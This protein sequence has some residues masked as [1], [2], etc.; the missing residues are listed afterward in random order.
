MSDFRTCAFARQLK[1]L[2]IQA[3]LKQPVAWYWFIFI[4][5]DVYAKTNCYVAYRRCLLLSLLLLKTALPFK[6]GILTQTS[7]YGSPRGK[8][9]NKTYFKTGQLKNTSQIFL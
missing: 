7:N 5:Y 4:I 9:K 8:E 3:L 2:N 1:L 6:Y